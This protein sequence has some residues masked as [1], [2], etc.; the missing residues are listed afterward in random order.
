MRDLSVNAVEDWSV[1]RLHSNVK[2]TIYLAAD[3]SLK[4][5]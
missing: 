5:L 4:L 2:K 1:L 3:L